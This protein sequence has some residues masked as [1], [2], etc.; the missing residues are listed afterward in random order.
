M[1]NAF[2]LFKVTLR[3]VKKMKPCGLVERPKFK[4]DRASIQKPSHGI[5]RNL[6]GESCMYQRMWERVFGLIFAG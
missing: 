5:K 3:C 2:A 6:V 4:F 1:K